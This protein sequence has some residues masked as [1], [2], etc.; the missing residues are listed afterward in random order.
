M[1]VFDFQKMRHFFG[2]LNHRDLVSFMLIEL[3]FRAVSCCS[4]DTFLSASAKTRSFLKGCA[5]YFFVIRLLTL[6]VLKVVFTL[7]TTNMLPTFHAQFSSEERKHQ[8]TYVVALLQFSQWNL[9]VI[10][11]SNCSSSPLFRCRQLIREILGHFNVWPDL[12]GKN[13]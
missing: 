13:V 11:L 10:F 4:F 8:N 7:K 1:S 2:I 9:H 3:L 12:C 6:T 5:T